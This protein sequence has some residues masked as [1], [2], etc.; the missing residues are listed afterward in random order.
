MSVIFELKKGGAAAST[1]AIRSALLAYRTS[2]EPQY[3]LDDCTFAARLNLHLASKL[4]N[5]LSHTCNSNSDSP[6][7]LICA[8]E[9]SRRHAAPFV[10]HF[11]NQFPRVLAYDDCRCRTSGMP[12]NV[13]ESFLDDSKQRRFH[14]LR[15]AAEI[16]RNLKIDSHAA[17]SLKAFGVPT[18][19]GRQARLI[20]E[21]R[22]EQ[23]R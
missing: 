11:Q 8:V 10:F 4:L 13:G 15:E 1:A 20:Q 22:M 17:S 2:E 19:C 23:V 18:Q 6:G 7:R 5:A 12:V 9:Y 16:R 21:R 3:R 14:L